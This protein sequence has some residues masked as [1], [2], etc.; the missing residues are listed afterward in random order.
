MQVS[1]LIDQNCT[2]IPAARIQQLYTW[3]AADYACNR[4]YIHESISPTRVGRI[5]KYYARIN[6][7]ISLVAPCQVV[8]MYHH[9]IVQYIT[10]TMPPDDNPYV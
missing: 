9:I 2:Y 10:L 7:N 3:L 4:A 1:A 5:V 6:S 8:I